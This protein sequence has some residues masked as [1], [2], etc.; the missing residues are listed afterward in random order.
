MTI[1]KKIKANP[2]P[3]NECRHGGRR[4]AN[5]SRSAE[6]AGRVWRCA[7]EHGPLATIP[8]PGLRLRTGN[9]LTS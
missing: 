4:S 5:R 2:F 9:Q 7:P 1:T 8:A 6:I 3:M